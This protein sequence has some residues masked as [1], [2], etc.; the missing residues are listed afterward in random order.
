MKNFFEEQ[1]EKL[2]RTRTEQGAKVS[3][4]AESV[5]QWEADMSVPR[6]PIATLAVGYDVAESRM[7][8]EVMA[9]RRRIEARKAK[10]PAVK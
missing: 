6:V 5:R 7:E 1:R 8:K 3:A 9:L 2:D 4:S 10:R